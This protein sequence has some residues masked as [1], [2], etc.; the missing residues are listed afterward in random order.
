MNF[1][2]WILDILLIYPKIWIGWIKLFLRFVLSGI[3]LFL[4]LSPWKKIFFIVGSIQTF[5]AARPWIEYSV[6]FLEQKEV[7]QISVKS[8]LW[9]LFLL[10]FNFFG[11]LFF[12]EKFF[13]FNFFFQ[14]SVSLL[15]GIGILYPNLLFTNFLKQEDYTFSIHFYIF[16]FFHTLTTFLHIVYLFQK[17]K[18]KHENISS[19]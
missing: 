9:I 12:I 15:V 11:N 10:I 4:G 8:N 13:Y 14:I 7:L 5:Y 19:T 3:Q 2:N 16:V 17:R 18:F 6:Q 1:K